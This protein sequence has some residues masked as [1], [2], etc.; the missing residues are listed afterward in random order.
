M[1]RVDRY[2]QAS[3]RSAVPAASFAVL[4]AIAAV[5]CPPRA[6]AQAVSI[7]QVSGQV[8]DVTGSAVPN[9]A[10]KM[11]EIAKGVTHDTVSD[12]AGRYT[13]PNLPVILPVGSIREWIQ[14]L[15]PIGNP[16]ASQ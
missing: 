2:C 4:C 7:A 6:F 14:E 15:C 8:T 16:V 12:G 1:T 3:A 10:I 5:F 13:L 9:A 11:I